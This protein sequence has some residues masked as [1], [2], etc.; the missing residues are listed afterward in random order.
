MNVVLAVALVLALA[1]M[2]S[3]WYTLK[4]RAGVKQRG[5]FGP[6]PIP[7]VPLE[8]LD[9]IFAFTPLG[10]SLE[11]E[12]LFVGQVGV[13]GTSIH[14]AT[15][16][17]EAW[18][19]S[20]LAKKSRALFEF[21]TCTGKTTYAW[22]RN[23]PAG[24]EIVTLTLGPDQ[25]ASYLAEAGDHARDS[26]RAL[27]ETTHDRFYYTGTVVEPRVTQL[28][29]DSKHFDEAPYRD[30]FDLIFVDG[31]HARSY[32]ASDSAKALRM[33]KPGGLIL[34]HD[35]AGPRVPGVFKA[36]NE[37]ARTLPLVHVAGTKLVAYRKPAR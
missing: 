16:D 4:Y 31:S 7:K 23:A 25:L 3:G 36:L 6:W 22:A 17:L 1:G 15:T 28:F 30:H 32:V 14:G 20:V 18:V 29:G 33:C 34:W 12:V 13:R 5:M 37:L 9:P 21:G 10:P 2:G 26:R 8:D 27:T 24:A 11:T 35:Y 19:L